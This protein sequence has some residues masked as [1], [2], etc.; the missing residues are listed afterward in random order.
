MNT[1]SFT[2]L[3]VSGGRTRWIPCWCRVD[4]LGAVR[5][6][7]AIRRRSRLRRSLVHCHSARIG[8]LERL[9][10]FVLPQ[11]LTRCRGWRTSR[12]GLEECDQQCW[13]GS[14]SQGLLGRASLS[15]PFYL[16]RIVIA[17]ESSFSQSEHCIRQG[18]CRMMPLSTVVS[19]VN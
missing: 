2:L 12:M 4:L 8:Q 5:I 17:D 18:V 16:L 13:I 7:Y 1:I 10:R 6:D 3:L 19:R 15:P 14:R 11:G 9:L